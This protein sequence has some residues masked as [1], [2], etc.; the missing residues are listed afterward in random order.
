MG[1][2][3]NHP[4]TDGFS[5]INHPLL[6]TFILGNLHIL[7]KN[8]ISS[9]SGSSLAGWP[10]AASRRCSKDTWKHHGDFK[11]WAIDDIQKARICLW[12]MNYIYTYRNI[13]QYM[14]IYIYICIILWHILTSVL[15]ALRCARFK[16]SVVW[17]TDPYLFFTVILLSTGVVDNE[18][19]PLVN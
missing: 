18:W 15:A 17:W 10:A 4:F 9:D 16:K 6:G 8:G 19:Y 7:L 1:V 2:S 14:N 3:L 12:I 11:K 13:R 5:F